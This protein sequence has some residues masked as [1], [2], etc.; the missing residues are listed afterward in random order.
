MTTINSA[1]DPRELRNAFG[2][3]MTGVTVVTTMDGESPVGF[4]A[5]SFSSVS[6][7]P[8]LLLIC[9][10]NNSANY[11]TFTQS[12]GFAVNILAEDQTEISNT[13]AR[14]SDDRFAAVDWRQGPKGSPILSGVCAW[15]DCSMEQVVEAGDHVILIGRVAAFDTSELGGLGY[16]SGGYFTRALETQAARA[17]ASDARAR[18]S[19][20]VVRDGAVLLEGSAS[21]GWRLPTANQSAD[22]SGGQRQRLSASFALGLNDFYIYSVYDN[23]ETQVQHI[24]FRCRAEAGVPAQ[25]Q[26]VALTELERFQL[27]DS[28]EQTLMRRYIAETSLGNFKIYLGDQDSGE[29]QEGE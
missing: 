26:F 23:A 16:A 12:E 2:R 20:V 9:L 21:E 25:G 27:A 4:T 8:P 15:F 13:F 24:V 29:I 17:I 5:N 14:P 19:A 6:L 10:A 22:A 18:V 11:D 7:D 1:I 3:F 28:A